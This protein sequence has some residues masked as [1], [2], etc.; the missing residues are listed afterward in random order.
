MRNL[1]GL[2]CSIFAL[3]LAACGGGGGGGGGSTPAA[4]IDPNLTVPFQTAAANLVNNG[5]NQNFTVTGWINNSTLANPV[6][7]TPITGSGSLT[8][9]P[10]STTTFNGAP[11]LQATEVIV[12]SA[13]AN[14]QS[15][16]LA[17]TANNFYD[18]S[19]YTKVGSVINGETTFISPYTYPA[20]VKAGSTG[21]LG[22]GT[23]G[24]G[25]TLTTT[26][27]AY[28]VAT[29]SANSLL[30]TIVSTKNID[31]GIAGTVQDQTVYRIT[32]SGAI[33]LVSE[34]VQQSSTGSVYESLTFAF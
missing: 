34:N 4:V 6:P 12:G 33:S 1:K 25:L 22:S 28:S 32:T 29:D 21:T 11:A 18:P 10:P 24:G 26:T 3:V 2:A 16:P 20:T 7:N 5:I 23:S 30:V 17:G 8:I 9:G 31:N 15:I 13:S 19:N 14:G 27:T